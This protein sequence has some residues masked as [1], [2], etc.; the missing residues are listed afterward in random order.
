MQTRYVAP[1]HTSDDTNAE[2]ESFFLCCFVFLCT[3]ARSTQLFFIL[4]LLV[5]NP[6]ACI[7]Y[8]P[9]LLFLSRCSHHLVHNVPGWV[10]I[11][12]SWYIFGPVPIMS[13]LSLLFMTGAPHASRCLCPSC[14]RNWSASKL[15]KRYMSTCTYDK[16]IVVDVIQYMLS[17]GARRTF[18]C[19]C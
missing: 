13:S 19:Q 5:P 14:L 16:M 11:A 2:A 6:N 4:L 1:H 8:T 18:Y 7:L 17:S 9:F 15:Q 3:V 12:S 10:V